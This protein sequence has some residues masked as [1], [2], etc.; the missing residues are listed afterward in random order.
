MSLLDKLERALGRFAIPGISL[1]LVIGQVFVVLA[2]M[3]GILTPGTAGARAAAGARRPV[4]AAR[5]VPLPAAGRSAAGC[6]G[7]SFLVF[8]WWI[9]Y[10]MGNALEGYWGA[11]RYNLFLL[12]GYLLTVGLGFSSRSGP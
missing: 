9:F 8:A 11:F 7:S 2:T 10:F 6:W 12:I 5:D 1:Y 3:A 4:V